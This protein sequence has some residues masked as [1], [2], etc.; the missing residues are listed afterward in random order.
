MSKTKTKNTK[1]YKL[2]FASGTSGAI[3]ASFL[4]IGIVLQYTLALIV[5]YIFANIWAKDYTK[6]KPQLRRIWHVA[7]ALVIVSIV[8]LI[9]IVAYNDVK[10]GLFN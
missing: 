7:N 6:D 2:P 4:I 1:P 10:S 3:A 9:L 5:G 8:G